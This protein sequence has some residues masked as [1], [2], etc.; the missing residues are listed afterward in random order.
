MENEELDPRERKTMY[1]NII[2]TFLESDA[3]ANTIP[4]TRH[5]ETREAEKSDEEHT[6][7]SFT[8]G[9]TKEKISP[10]TLRNKSK[11]ADPKI[12]VFTTGDEIGLVKIVDEAQS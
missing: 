12:Y 9:G 4:V 8:I 1:D 10:V 5:K 7:Y 3:T 2:S 6:Y 11:E